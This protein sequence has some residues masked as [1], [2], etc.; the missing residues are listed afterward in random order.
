M[1]PTGSETTKLYEK[2]QRWL[3]TAELQVTATNHAQVLDEQD[4]SCPI[5]EKGEKK[6]QAEKRSLKKGWEG[7]LS[8][9]F[10]LIQAENHQL[11]LFIWYLHISILHTVSVLRL[12]ENIVPL[13]PC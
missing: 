12:Q 8:V 11:L 4:E 2:R 10:V 13:H 1:T 3:N 6:S 9:S 7:E 5:K